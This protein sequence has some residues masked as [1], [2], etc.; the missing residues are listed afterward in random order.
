MAN[1]QTPNNASRRPEH[2]GRGYALSD[3]PG[4]ADVLIGKPEKFGDRVGPHA[5]AE[6]WRWFG[7]PARQPECWLDVRARDVEPDVAAERIRT[8]RRNVHG[9]LRDVDALEIECVRAKASGRGRKSGEV[10]RWFGGSLEWEVQWTGK[11]DLPDER[12]EI[13][14]ETCVPVPFDL[15]FPAG[16]AW[17]RQP[18]ELSPE[19]I[20]WG[21][22]RPENVRGSYAVYWH[23]SGQYLRPDGTERVNYETGKFCHLYRPQLIDA[24]GETCWAKMIVRETLDPA[25]LVVYMPLAWLLSAAYPVTLDPTFGYTSVGGSTGGGGANDWDSHGPE[26][27]TSDGTLDSFHC[28]TLDV[29][30]GMTAGVYDDSGGAPNNL[31][32]NTGEFSTSAG[33]WSSANFDNSNT[34]VTS[35]ADYWLAMMCNA[36]FRIPYDRPDG[37]ARRYGWGTTYSAG[38]MPATAPSHSTY[39]KYRY[40]RYVTCTET[41]VAFFPYHVRSNTKFH[42]SLLLR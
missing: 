34:A 1:N 11:A 25:E 41:G 18:E 30:T 26:S 3:L 4:R 8:V 33:A 15:D 29:E 12:V 38:V 21:H 14:G 13:D 24:K 42:N 36:N 5:R 31:L 20:D 35:G 32:V 28:Y 37:Y 27:P 22:T 23:R 40:S 6:K 9:S 17:W 2:Q 39:A 16:L 10:H 7:D 19:E